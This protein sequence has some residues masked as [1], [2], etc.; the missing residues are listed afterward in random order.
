M[1]MMKINLVKEV[2]MMARVKIKNEV[3]LSEIE[4]EP[5]D[6]ESQWDLCLQLG[7]YIYDDKD[8][9]YGY[10]FMYRKPGGDLQPA[11]GGA[12]I[13]SLEVAEKLIQE[14][15]NRGWGDQIY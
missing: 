1:R 2:L 11:R 7:L 9:E 4:N 13:P 8:E 6:S 3:R 10:R 14:A 5:F 15:R 12:R